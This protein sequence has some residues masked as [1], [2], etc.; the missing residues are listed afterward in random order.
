MDRNNPNYHKLGK[1]IIRINPLTQEIDYWLSD[2]L[3]WRTARI[4]TNV[5]EWKRGLRY[6]EVPYEDTWA[7]PME[8]Y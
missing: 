7:E 4:I 8:G 3:C 2:K 5:R 6:K 1:N